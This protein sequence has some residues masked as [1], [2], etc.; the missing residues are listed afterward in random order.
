V[1]GDQSADR[2]ITAHLPSRKT[3]VGREPPASSW[4]E[5]SFSPIARQPGRRL[6]TLI[7]MSAMDRSAVEPAT[8]DHALWER[9][10]RREPAALGELYTRYGRDVHAFAVRRTGSYA[11]ADDTLQATFVTAWRQ[12]A[13]ADPGPLRK[14]SARSWLLT[15][16]HNEVRNMT[17]AKRRLTRFLAGQPIPAYHPDHADAIAARLDSERL[18]AE[19]R[20]ALGRL[21]KHERQTIELVY[22]AELSVAEAAAVLGVAPGTV[23]ARLLRARRRLPG[24]LDSIDHEDLS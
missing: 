20:A 14:P 6:R 13:V 15:L 17:R 11:S 12:F 9:L 4:L 21:P 1:V 2:E 8:S 10:R 22:W 19:V 24:M 3:L 16:A 23:K 5:L 18:I 7:G